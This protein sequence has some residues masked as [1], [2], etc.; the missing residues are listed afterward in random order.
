MQR[1][2]HVIN[3]I[4]K[5]VVCGTEFR[6]PPSAKKVTCSKECS[7]IRKKETHEG[8]KN[9]WSEESKRRIA[10]R[11]KQKTLSLERRLQRKA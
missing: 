2:P 6:C 8:K 7:R 5:C 11:G 9:L 1:S 3:M 4:K 10:E